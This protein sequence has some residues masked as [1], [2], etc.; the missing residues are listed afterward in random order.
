MDCER[1]NSFLSQKALLVLGGLQPVVKAEALPC[2]GHGLQWLEKTERWEGEK[3]E[4]GKK[5]R[6]DFFIGPNQVQASHKK[7]FCSEIYYYFDTAH[8]LLMVCVSKEL[9]RNLRSLFTC[10]PLS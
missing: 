9:F 1:G 10:P 2:E 3:G 5:E 8:T 6:K 7:H 4:K